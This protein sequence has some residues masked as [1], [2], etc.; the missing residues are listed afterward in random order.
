MLKIWDKIVRLFS[1]RKMEIDETINK[2]FE[3]MAFKINAEIKTDTSVDNLFSSIIPL[4]HNYCNAVLLLASNERRLPAMALLRVLAELALRV[5][6]CLY[7]DNPLKE[8]VDVRI[9]RWLKE[10]YKQRKRNLKKRLLVADTK[11]KKNIENEIK[12]L[13]SEIEKIPYKFAGDLYNSLADLPPD[14]KNK[15]YPLLYGTFNQAIHPDLLVL[16]KLGKIN[17]NVRTYSGDFNDI[18]ID[19]LK[20]YCMTA[21]FNI[22]SVVRVHYKWDYEDMKS[23]YLAI[24]REFAAKE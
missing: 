8:T 19:A 3:E 21:A 24:K 18:S 17:N 15:I 13:E 10:S 9:E 7:E 23:E 11:E 22:L 5:I 6:W 12:Y 14:Y 4:A 20:I 1:K 16:R 2:W